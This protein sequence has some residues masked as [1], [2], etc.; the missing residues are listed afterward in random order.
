MSAVKLH[1]HETQA[2]RFEPISEALRPTNPQLP[3]RVFSNTT[4]RHRLRADLHFESAVIF[5]NPI[6]IALEWH[7]RKHKT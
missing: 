4:T 6:T 7:L 3:L 5:G 2:L 1:D